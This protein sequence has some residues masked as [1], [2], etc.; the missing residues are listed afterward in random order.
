MFLI[1][2]IVFLCNFLILEIAFAHFLLFIIGTQSKK[3]DRVT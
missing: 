3:A 2:N 1:D